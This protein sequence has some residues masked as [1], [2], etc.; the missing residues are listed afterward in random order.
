MNLI[1]IGLCCLAL[2]SAAVSLAHAQEGEL[3]SDGL[4]LWLTAKDGL[5]V[6]DGSVAA[7]HDRSGNELDAIVPESFEY[8]HHS[9]D[10]SVRFSKQRLLCIKGN[11]LPPD[12][13]E[14]TFIVVGQVDSTQG[15]SFVAN[16]RSSVPLIQLDVDESG[17]A[18]F[19]VRDKSSRTLRSLAPADLGKKSVFVGVLTDL[20]DNRC[21]AQV[22]VD[23]ERGAAD[24]GPITTP[25][26]GDTTWLGGLPLGN[27][28][29]TL[30]GSISEV[31]MYDH[32][33][34]TKQ[35]EAI[36]DHLI[37]KHDIPPSPPPV[38]DSFNVLDTQHFR[39]AVSQE[40]S[41]DVCIVGAGS[42]GV[43]AAVAAAR[44][45]VRVILVERQDLLGGTGTNA[46]VSAWEP[47][48]GCS[49]A[50]EIFHR[51]REIPG[52]TGVATWHPHESKIS[53]GLWFI[54]EGV[55]Y[56][57]TL[58]RAGVPRQE[59]AAVPFDPE[60]FD[61]VVRAM[62]DETG[63]VR[64]LDRTIFFRAE[65]NAEATRVE[66][67]LV[68]DEQ[69]RVMRVRAKVFLDC[70]GCVYLCRA[71]GCETML[72]VD[73]RSRFNESSAPEKGFL[74]LNAISRCYMVRPS[75][76][77]EQEPALEPPIPAFARTAHVT[78][79]EDGI[80]VINPLPMLPGRAL[81]D[82][83]YDECL[84]RTDK[85]VHAHWHWLQQ[86][87]EFDGYEFH[88]I[89]PMLGIRESY[90]VVTQYVLRQADLEAGLPGQTH[91]DIIAVADH[92]CDIHGAGGH[93]S[94]VTT[95][96][97][98][99]YRCL[100][101]LEKWENLLVACRGSGF[102]KIAASSCRLQRTMIQLGHAAG[103]AAA[104]A[105]ESD[106][107]MDQIDI[108]ELVSSLDARSRYPDPIGEKSHGDTESRR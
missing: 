97:G 85:A 88:R 21:E 33:L 96:Y 93:L 70:T 44:R 105:V 14:M 99:P 48:P 94:A 81:I 36:T 55:P 47:G 77:P 101:P 46:F 5:D 82:L 68:E 59:M 6:A 19:I 9:R 71:L 74:R 11:L 4:R 95:A 1:R 65:P 45:G 72:G 3:R 12:A 10:Q 104:M 107:P 18:R 23:G 60:A 83:G 20:G 64:L 57:R 34:P 49:I 37:S 75:S 98:V 31:I 40:L 51:M 15:V 43:A 7:W 26:V 32:A 79:Y 16:R 61:R 42:A 17:M 25:L 39:A 41:T 58:R 89:A 52:A 54:T 30:D 13:R 22:L 90:R 56:S 38:P 8:P 67:I 102:S 50:E 35:L 27:R 100:I 24:S 29:Y 53:M 80:R 2:G 28:L 69:K 86:H 63:S 66:S 78:G 103:V 73:P 62:L 76:Q 91:S 92:P 106:R 108:P 84:R 87:T